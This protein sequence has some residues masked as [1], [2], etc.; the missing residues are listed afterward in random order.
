MH[1]Y[2]GFLVRFTG[3]V[4]SI[5]FIIKQNWYRNWNI[6]ELTWNR[7]KSEN[8]LYWDHVNW[9]RIDS[10]NQ[11]W[12]PVLVGIILWGE[13]PWFFVQSVNP[14]RTGLRKTG[15][16]SPLKTTFTLQLKRASDE[17]L[18]VR[19]WL[20]IDN[21]FAKHLMSN[22]NLPNLKENLFSFHQ[23]PAF[24]GKAGHSQILIQFRALLAIWDDYTKLSCPCLHPTP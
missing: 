23:P 21:S 5:Y 6:S 11:R 13:R 4:L 16:S 10:G 14:S 9:N 15:Q 8:K 2:R 24:D 1:Q 3:L 17:I 20:T 12:Q 18:I 22:L 7:T 19:L